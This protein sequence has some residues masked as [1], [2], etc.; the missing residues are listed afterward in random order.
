MSELSTENWVAILLI[1]SFFMAGIGT[2]LFGRISVKHIAREMEKEGLEQPLWDKGI[3]SIG[4][5]YAL[6]IVFPKLKSILVDVD[7]IK[8]H[9]R[10]K[11]K[12]I[13]LLYVASVFIFLILIFVV[14]YLYGPES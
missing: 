11:D 3:G 2:F 5:T 1:I 12:K 9:T 14:V 6:T 10:E 4:F 7:T 8:R 13:A